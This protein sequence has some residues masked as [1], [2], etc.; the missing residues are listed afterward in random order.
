MTFMRV[1]PGEPWVRLEGFA[2]PDE[3]LAEYRRLVAAR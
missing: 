1:A 2:T 3:L